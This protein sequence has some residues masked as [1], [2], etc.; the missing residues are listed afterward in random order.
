MPSLRLP[1]AVLGAALVA[2]CGGGDAPALGGDDAWVVRLG[3]AR[4]SQSELDDALGGGPAGLDS[5]TARTQYIDQWID[6][7]LL[8]QQ[9]LATGLDEA[10]DVRRRLDA[11]RRATLETAYLDRYF[12]D[13]PA[14]PSD[15]DLEAY[16]RAQGARLVLPE[17]Y[18]RV[19][20]L[21]P[22]PGRAAAAAEALAEVAASPIADSLFSIA[23][24][25]F[26]QDPD[27]AR[28]LGQQFLP[29]SR[30]D[31]LDPALADRVAALAPGK[32]E[33]LGASE[34]PF[35]VAV[36]ERAP[37]GVVPPLSLLRPELTERLA[38]Q[39]RKDAAARLL[40]QLR[41]E[42]QARGRLDIR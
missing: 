4:L 3:D 40:Q 12:A 5:A 32:V 30:L 21:R 28:A 24:A 34:R 18:L 19:W 13:N 14:E 26:S 10:P 15:A 8:T 35:V 36:A 22:E 27:G 17:P 2:A 16:Y 25:R 38:I 42:A 33:T 20:L 9:A 7:E 23:A 6:R 29:A 31:E 41:A 37:A 1:L 11:A 39:R